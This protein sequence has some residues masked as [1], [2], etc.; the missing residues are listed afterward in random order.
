MNNEEDETAK[1]IAHVWERYQN[2]SEEDENYGMRGVFKE[3]KI[4]EEE[5]RKRRSGRG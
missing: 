5:W 1:I 4:E 2:M 3:I